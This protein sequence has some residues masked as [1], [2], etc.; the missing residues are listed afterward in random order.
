MDINSRLEFAADPKTVHQMMTNKQWLEELVSRTDATS[1]T[2]DIAGDTTRIQMALPAPQDLA[3]F[4]GSALKLNQTIQWGD[5]AADGSR[6]GSLV[7]EVPGMPVHMNGRARLY[8]GGKGTV[9][10]YTGDLTVN[11]PFMGKKIEQQAAPYV[12]DAIDA[13]QSA[14]DDWLAAHS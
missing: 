2:I 6:E 11:I 1:H 13:Q 10:D 12:K 5:A 7:I 14:G 4:A 8:P 3:R 9:V